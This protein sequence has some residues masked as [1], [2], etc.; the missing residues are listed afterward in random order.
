MGP[1]SVLSG[2][3]MGGEKRIDLREY[4]FASW[5]KKREEEGNLRASAQIYSPLSSLFPLGKS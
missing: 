2:W 4:M 3:V 1:G 5:K